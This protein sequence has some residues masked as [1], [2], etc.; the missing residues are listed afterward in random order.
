[1]T[2]IPKRIRDAVQERSQGTCEVCGTHGADH[3][4]HRRLRA[5]GGRHDPINLLHIHGIPCHLDIHLNPERS[6]ALGHLVHGWA[7]PAD[8][9]VVHREAS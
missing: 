8:V 4:H 6:Y 7:D 5:Q 2:A 9:P 3:I 1:M